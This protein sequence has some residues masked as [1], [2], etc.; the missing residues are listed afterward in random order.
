MAKNRRLS[1][2]ELKLIALII[3]ALEPIAKL[4]DAISRI[5]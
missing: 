4:L 1:P 2:D 5:R 3:S